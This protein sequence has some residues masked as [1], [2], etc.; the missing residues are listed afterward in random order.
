MLR[1]PSEHV[2]NSTRSFSVKA[3]T[4]ESKLECIKS[5]QFK[6]RYKR[7]PILQKKK[8]HA[9]SVKQSK[10]RPMDVRGI[11]KSVLGTAKGTPQI[12]REFI[13]GL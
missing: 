8:G 3:T 2:T 4:P 6:T 12:S 7:L 5:S 13:I 11:R 9:T 1:K 10:P